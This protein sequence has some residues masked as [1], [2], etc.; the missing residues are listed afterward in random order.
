MNLKHLAIWS[1]EMMLKKIKPLKAV[2]AAFLC[3]A[4]LSGCENTEYYPSEIVVSD[5]DNIGEE[6]KSF[7]AE[8]CG[9]RLE[10][11]VERAVSL[12]PAMTEIICELGFQNTLVAVS[13]YC[14]YPEDLSLKTVGSTENP[15]IEAIIELAPDAVFTLSLLSERDIYTLNRAGIA[16]LTP[17]TPESLEEYYAMYRETAAAF[18][19]READDSGKL[20]A[21]ETANDARNRLESA[22]VELGSFVY[23]TEKLTIAGNET[24]AGAVLE[25]CGE[26]LC[27]ESGYVLSKECEGVVPE[28]IIASDKLTEPKIRSDNTLAAMI[29]GGAKIIYVNSGYFERPTARTAEVFSQL[30]E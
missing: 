25:L 11:A 16:V 6:E 29:S 22:A 20:K 3:A 2:F 27:K 15:D 18:Y 8:S 26:N 17:K 24:F 28:Y 19:G 14:D 9:Q 7:P 5:T 10:K 1:N 23:V 12:S 21:V 13:S 4:V 30:K